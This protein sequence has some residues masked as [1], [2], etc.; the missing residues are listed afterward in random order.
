[1][2]GCTL[3]G[4]ALRQ[5][6]PESAG[7][8]QQAGVC[9]AAGVCRGGAGGD[10]RH[11]LPRQGTAQQQERHQE[12]PVPGISASQSGAR[13]L[14]FQPECCLFS[15]HHLNNPGVGP[16]HAQH[17]HDAI[18]FLANSDLYLIFKQK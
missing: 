12:L 5:C 18:D 16:S 15:L 3:A 17:L 8:R 10:P 14:S 4:Q 11:C 6:Y 13:V 9:L 1:V 7:R 2:G